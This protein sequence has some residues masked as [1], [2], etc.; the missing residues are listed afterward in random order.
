[1]RTK[2]SLAVIAPIVVSLLAACS[3][4]HHGAALT[5]QAA[6]RKAQD[7]AVGSGSS[8]SS[9][10]VANTTKYRD[11]G[12]H[13]ATGRSGSAVIQSRALLAKDATT[14]VEVTTGVI[15]AQVGIGSLSHVQVIPITIDGSAQDALNYK[16]A[17]GTWSHTFSGMARNDSVQV[18][19]NVIG[20]DASRT[21][22]ITTLDTVKRRPDLA[23]QSLVGPARAYVHAPVTFTANVAELNG[24]VG[25]RADCLLSVDG[26]QVDQAMG[27]WVDAG[28]SVSCAFHATFA[29]TGTHNVGVS[30]ANVV[31]ADWDLSNNTA[32]TTIQIVDPVVP[33]GYV[34]SASS[35]SFSSQ[36]YEQ[37]SGYWSGYSYYDSA[38]GTTSSAFIQGRTTQHTFQFPIQQVS[39]NITVDGAAI[40]QQTARSFSQ[41]YDNHYYNCSYYYDVGVSGTVCNLDGGGYSEA[42]FNRYGDMVTYYSYYSNYSCG[43]FGCTY[44]YTSGGGT[45]TDGNGPFDIGNTDQFTLSLTDAGGTIYNAATPPL[46]TQPFSNGPYTYNTCNGYYGGGYCSSSSYSESGKHLY[47]ETPLGAF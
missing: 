14:L 28:S 2:P 1:M 13:P 9:L 4:P 5:P 36:Y 11:D 12:L 33:L 26:Q 23:A 15:D 30:I 6:Q 27:I 3:G 34:A 19:S 21:D 42:S 16:P 41:P 17:G 25:A 29:T 7:A 18:Q 31:P 39:A 32:K 20:V 35:S 24:D 22:V 37:Y 40:V 46:Q 47:A 45:R 10:F 8:I 43:W 38:S 44:G